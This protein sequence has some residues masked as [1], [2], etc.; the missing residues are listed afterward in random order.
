M[1]EVGSKIFSIRMCGLVS[2]C[3]DEDDA[4]D[5]DEVDKDED[6]DEDEDGDYDVRYSA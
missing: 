3:S 1:R 2:V 6:E 5:E 4:E